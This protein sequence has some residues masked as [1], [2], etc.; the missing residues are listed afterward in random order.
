MVRCISSIPR[1]SKLA[2]GSFYSPTPS[3]QHEGFAGHDSL[4]DIGLVD[5]EGRVYD[6]E[7]GSFLSADPNVQY[8]FSSQGYD[9]YIYVNDNPLSLSDPSG[10]FSLSGMLSAGDPMAGFFPQQ[11]GQVLGVV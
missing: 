5:M 3:D 8:P 6:P 1:G 10:Y 9:R 11:Y 2:P 4:G 7:V